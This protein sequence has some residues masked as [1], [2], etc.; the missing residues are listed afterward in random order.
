MHYFLGFIRLFT[1][2]TFSNIYFQPSI[3]FSIS[4]S[5][6]CWLI[7]CLRYFFFALCSDNYFNQLLCRDNVNFRA[8]WFDQ[9]ESLVLCSFFFSFLFEL[10]D[11]SPD[12]IFQMDVLSFSSNFLFL[13]V[14]ILGDWL[15]ALISDCLLFLSS[16][17]LN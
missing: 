8:I 5:S 14:V 1:R 4:S 7:G 12:M 2:Y 10:H 9:F 6:Q 11:Y 13:Q 15:S 3:T 16:D 17:S